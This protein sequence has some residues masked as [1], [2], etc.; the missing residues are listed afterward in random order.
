MSGKQ[1]FYPRTPQPGLFG[2]TESQVR[3]ADYEAVGAF[4]LKRL[5]KIFA[6]V[7]PKPYVLRNSKNTPLYL[8]CF[9]AGNPKGAPTAVKI[10]QESM[11]K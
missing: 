11:G 6:R 5:K 9:A 7:A 2:A 8:F 4:F 10:A 3:E 1:E